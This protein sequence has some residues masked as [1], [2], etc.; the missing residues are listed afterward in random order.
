MR[1]T[2]KFARAFACALLV[3]AV[4]AA[5]AQKSPQDQHGI[6]VQNLDRA[7]KPGDDFFRFTNGAW[8]QR[9]QIQP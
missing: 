6:A 1:E 4:G 5:S 8:L 9:I 2:F 7:V 3:L